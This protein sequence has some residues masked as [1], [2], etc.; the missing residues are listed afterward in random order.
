MQNLLQTR[1]I[2]KNFHKKKISRSFRSLETGGGSDRRWRCAEFPPNGFLR[3]QTPFGKNAEDRDLISFIFR[4][5]EL[6][7]ILATSEAFFF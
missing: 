3:V 2:K 7:N 5:G 4:N 1:N 6:T